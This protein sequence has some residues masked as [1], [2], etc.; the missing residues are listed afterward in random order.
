MDSSKAEDTFF[1][2]AETF[3][4]GAGTVLAGE[5]RAGPSTYSW[6]DSMNLS[7]VSEDSI[8]VFL[9]E[10][11]TTLVPEGPAA[12]RL[13]GTFP[14]TSEYAGMNFLLTNGSNQVIHLLLYL[15]RLIQGCTKYFQ[16][17]FSPLDGL[18]VKLWFCNK[19][20]NKVF[21]NR[22]REED[23]F[24]NNFLFERRS[25]RDSF[26]LPVEAATCFPLV[27]RAWG[28]SSSDIS[29]KS[30]IWNYVF[31]RSEV[32]TTSA[33]WGSKTSSE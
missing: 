10:V 17:P 29:T 18:L 32:M 25:R 24:I 11:A 27:A 14:Q 7:T 33:T 30:L 22:Q 31:C 23:N 20:S 5:S 28:S 26:F 21:P 15:L 6:K 16:K 3:W 9:V 12:S 8:V 4:D 13:A 19:I 2:A 1:S